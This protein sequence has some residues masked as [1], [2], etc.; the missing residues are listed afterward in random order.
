MILEILV[1]FFN[2]YFMPICRKNFFSYAR[3]YAWLMIGLWLGGCGDAGAG[4]PSTQVRSGAAQ[5]ANAQASAEITEAG[6]EDLSL[7]D[8]ESMTPQELEQHTSKLRARYQQLQASN[9]KLQLTNNSLCEHLVTLRKEC[10]LVTPL[11]SAALVSTGCFGSSS[12]D[13]L[14][15]E[16]A[17]TLAIPWQVVIDE[18]YTSSPF[19]A[20]GGI[21]FTQKGSSPDTVINKTFAKIDLLHLMPVDGASNEQSVN[22]MKFKLFIGSHKIIGTKASRTWE[23]ENKRATINLRDLSKRGKSS[24]CNPVIANIM[25]DVREKVAAQGAG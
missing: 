12:V 1:C 13:A 5:A 7:L 4:Q 8:I 9:Q 11:S 2:R 20:S 21:T 10:P 3:S 23:S 18:Q 22:D 25:A 14:R 6:L 15:V 24:K 17:G 19:T 16:V